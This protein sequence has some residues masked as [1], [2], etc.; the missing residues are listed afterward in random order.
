MLRRLVGLAFVVASV[1]AVGAPQASVPLPSD[2]R[3]PSYYLALGDSL[4]AGYQPDPAIGRDQG[5]VARLQ[6]ALAHE[7]RLTV[8]NL[9]CAGAT[10]VTLLVGGGCGY[11]GAASQLAAAEQFLRRHPQRVSLVTIDI[12][13]NDINRCAAGGTIDQAC[14]LNAVGAAAAD[15]G[16]IARRLRAAAPGV[17]IVGMTYYDPYLSAWSRGPSGEALARQSLQLLTLLDQTLTGVYTAADM[18]VADVAGAFATTDLSTPAELSGVGTVP[19]A[20]A[21]ICTWTWMCAAGRSPDIHPTSA[22]YQVIADAFLARV[23]H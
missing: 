5:Y 6:Q 8:H 16:Q 3:G 14:A 17:R 12:G 15:L 1:L 2:L 7:H 23:G 9:G 11:D 21:R 18:R 19:L 10:T 13:G 20:V 22:G 4:A